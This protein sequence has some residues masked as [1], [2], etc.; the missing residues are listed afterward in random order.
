MPP[1]LSFLLFDVGD[2]KYKLIRKKTGYIK[3]RAYNS[4]Y[5]AEFERLGQSEGQL[6]RRY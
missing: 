2:I 5:L 3:E 6:S 1:C 4:I